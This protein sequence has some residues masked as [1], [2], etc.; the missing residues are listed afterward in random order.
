MPREELYARIDRRVEEMMLMG[1]QQELRDI[2]D[3]GYDPLLRPLQ[4]LGYKQ[5][6]AHLRDECAAEELIPA[7]QRET[8]RFAKR[9]L[10]WFRKLPHINWFDVHT[11]KI[12]DVIDEIIRR[13]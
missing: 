2:L 6:G 11:G 12:S 7:I 1:W 5:I 4:T 8:R 9:Q 10:T 13:L 3:M